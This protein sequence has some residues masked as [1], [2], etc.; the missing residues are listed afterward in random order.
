MFI[1]LNFFNLLLKGWLKFII[2]QV[3]IL[4]D[5]THLRLEFFMIHKDGSILISAIILFHLCYLIN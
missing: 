3:I 5:F 1:D 4:T 2:G